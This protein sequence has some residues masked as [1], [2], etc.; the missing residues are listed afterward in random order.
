MNEEAQKFTLHHMFEVKLTATMR[1]M[2]TGGSSVKIL[3]K[4]FA[5]CEP[6][7]IKYANKNLFLLAT[8]IRMKKLKNICFSDENW[9]CGKNVKKN[10]P[11]Y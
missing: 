10:V 9:F 6:L 4:S 1:L 2:A 7:M 5:M 11:K 3:Q 8:K